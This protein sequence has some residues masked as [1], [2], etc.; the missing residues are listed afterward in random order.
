MQDPTTALFQLALGIADPWKVDRLQFDLDKRRL[1]IQVGTSR[2]AR[3]PC[4]ECGLA[5][6][7]VHDTADKEWRHLNFFEHEAYLH[8]RV[9]RVRCPQHGVRQVAVPWARAGSGFTL[10][11]EA[12][13]MLLMREMPVKAASRILSEQDTRLWRVLTH[14]VDVARAS[15][16]FSEVT[17]IG[18]DETSHRRGHDYVSLFVDLGRAKVIFATPTRERKVVSEFRSDF[19]AHGGKPA[20]VSNFSSDLW[21]P[22]RDGVRD[23][24][25]NAALTVDRYHIV[26]M[27]SRAVDE[28]RR[29][30][31][32]Q[33]KGL[34]K[35]RY[36]WLKR[37]SRLTARQRE[38]LVYYRRRYQRTARAYEFRLDFDD[39]WSLPDA[40]LADAYLDDWCARVYRSKLKPLMDFVDTVEAHWDDILRWFKTRITNGVLEGINSLIQAVKRRARGYRTD[41]NYI[42]MIY[43]TAGKLDFRLPT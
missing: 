27:L 39:M 43:M 31:Q 20:A 21:R 8:A 2:G 6:C 16:D 4:P 24:F 7:P 18:V 25:E 28:V 1:D 9:P 15:E 13:A 37:P 35:T 30:E 17:E 12:L 42:A 5:D 33:A 40:E 34:K 36:L 14:Y 22:F 41:R 38:D 19:E 23:N 32:R 26:Q 11:F 10:L 29:G 3:F